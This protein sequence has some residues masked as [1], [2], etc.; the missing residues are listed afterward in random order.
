M[1]AREDPP[2]SFEPSARAPVTATLS[3]ESLSPEHLRALTQAISNVLKTEL[4]EFTFGEILDGLPTWSSF[5][6]FHTLYNTHDHPAQLHPTLCK[7]IIDTVRH[8][9]SNFDSLSLKYEPNVS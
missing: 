8:F 2:I 4:A 6:E 9:R 7:G 5:A 1:K 3:P